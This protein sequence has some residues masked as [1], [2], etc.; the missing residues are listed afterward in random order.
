LQ[1]LCIQPVS[2][3]TQ[4]KQIAADYCK[5]IS[6]YQCCA[7]SHQRPITINAMMEIAT[8]TNVVMT[9]LIKPQC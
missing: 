1:G 3:V 7:T 6:I 4:A 8:I 9:M 2:A 5:V